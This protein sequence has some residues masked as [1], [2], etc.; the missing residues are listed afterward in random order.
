MNK[1]TLLTYA[2]NPDGKL[3]NIDT[4]PNGLSCN[5]VCP[6]CHETLIAKNG[7]EKKEH[8]FAHKSN[9]DC[10]SGNETAIH[11]LAKEIILEEGLIPSISSKGQWEFIKAD[12]IEIEKVIEDIKPDIYAVVNGEPVAIEILV[13]HA[14]DM[15]KYNKIQR[16]DLRTIEINL[17]SVEQIDRNLIKQN[18]YDTNSL[19][20]VYDP[21]IMKSYLEQK[22]Q[23]LKQNGKVKNLS[24]GVVQQCPLSCYIINGRSLKMRNVRSSLCKSCLVSYVDGEKV[25][26]GGYI[27]GEIPMWFVQSNLSESRFMHIEEALSLSKT[28]KER[29]R[30]NSV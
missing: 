8:H 20:L 28:F 12:S 16:L 9:K 10:P 5:C 2:L 4:V 3:V 29:V 30:S 26:C 13:T 25:Y 14:V 17:S 7:G 19:A 15:I 18:I 27:N 11:L 1:H 21:M 22:M 23:I 6:G 24:S